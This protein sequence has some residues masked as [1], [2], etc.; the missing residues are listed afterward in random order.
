MAQALAWIVTS[1]VALIA[2]VGLVLVARILP[3]QPP[4]P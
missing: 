2:C 4:H 3:P 1:V